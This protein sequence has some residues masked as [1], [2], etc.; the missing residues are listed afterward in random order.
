MNDDQRKAVAEFMFNLAIGYLLLFTLG[1]ILQPDPLRS[2]IVSALV[3]VLS[4]AAL[5]VTAYR[6]LR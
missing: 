6:L 5:V 1:P 3:G 4:A 2:T